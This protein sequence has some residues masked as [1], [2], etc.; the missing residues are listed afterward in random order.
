[1]RKYAIASGL[2]AAGAGIVG[3]FLRQ[4]ELLR[5]FEPDTGLPVAGNASTVA[6]I[7]YTLLILAAAAGFAF[8][9][10]TRFKSKDTYSDAFAFRG[11]HLTVVAGLCAAALAASGVLCLLEARGGADFRIQ[12]AIAVLT[13]ASGAGLLGLTVSSLSGKG[14]K[15][16]LICAI[17]PEL[18]F[19]VWLLLLYRRN[20]TNPVRLEYAFQALA[21]VSAALS[22]YFTTGYAFGRPAPTLSALCNAAAVYFLITASADP[23]P[24]S[25]RLAFIAFAVFFAVNLIRLTD[26]L[27]FKLP[28]HL[29]SAAPSEE[30]AA[31]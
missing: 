7:T 31:E 19:T 21:I 2:L 15:L 18:F 6:L 12:A 24:L 10:K 25:Q 9:V 26:G 27:E 4:S 29:R 11:P 22:S 14:T 17:I 13:A 3:F 1:M 8:A 20:Q 5:A 23:L 28:K 16:S 30:K